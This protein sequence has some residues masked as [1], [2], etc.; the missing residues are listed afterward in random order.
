MLYRRALSLDP[1]NHYAMVGL[2][3]LLL[4]RGAAADAL[5]LAEDAAR[6]RSRRAPYRILLGDIRRATGD[7][8]GAR[9]A[10]EAALEIEPDNRQALQR[11]GR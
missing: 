3:R 10:W 6:R 2:A 1:Q 5:P 9:E 7:E 8:S 11:L 4:D